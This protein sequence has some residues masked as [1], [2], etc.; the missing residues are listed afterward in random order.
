MEI[1]TGPDPQS[2]EHATGLPPTPTTTPTPT[3]NPTPTPAAVFRPL[4]DPTESCGGSEI[5]MEQSQYYETISLS[6]YEVPPYVQQASP[7]Y[8]RLANTSNQKQSSL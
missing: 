1:T 2:T 3:P 8:E 4:V 5:P 7:T 6:S